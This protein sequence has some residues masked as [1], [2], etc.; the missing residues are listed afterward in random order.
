[1]IRR[2]VFVLVGLVLPLTAACSGDSLEPMSAT[3]SPAAIF[4]P[5][6]QPSP[7][8]SYVPTPAPSNAHPAGTRTG[9]LQVDK[10]LEAVESRQA[11]RIFGLLQ[12]VSWPCSRAPQNGGILGCRDGEADG[13]ESLVV[14]WGGCEGGFVRED[15]ADERVELWLRLNSGGVYAVLEASVRAQPAYRG[16]FVIVYAN[17]QALEVDYG[18]V[19]Y[20]NFGCGD[21]DGE[22]VVAD[23]AQSRGPVTFLLAPPG[24]VIPAPA[25]PY[26]L[27]TPVPPRAHPLGTRTGNPMIDAVI[28]AAES[29]DVAALSALVSY[30]PWPCT[31]EPGVG[32]VECPAGAAEG[33]AVE[34]FGWGGCDGSFYARGDPESFEGFAIFMG[35][36]TFNPRVYAVVRG[37]LFP[38][39][40]IPGKAFIAF[41]GGVL[42]K[43]DSSGV[44]FLT[45]TCGATPDAWIAQLAQ[46]TP[47]EFILPPV[48]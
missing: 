41:A 22:D 44:T 3:T 13:T 45:H 26:L 32:T 48:P 37:E 23:L 36:Q 43:V 14:A 8:T 25:T 4:S 6:P 35:R 34:V 40:A 42:V 15:A 7:T 21:L 47:L 11:S 33:T 29:R 38:G 2:L 28:A 18:G 31:A 20:L 24:T 46:F 12:F 19:T 16:Q 1:M 9:E 10:V 27:P 30:Y 17:G 39:I 5:A